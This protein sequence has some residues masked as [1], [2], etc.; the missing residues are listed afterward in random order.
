MA[1]WKSDSGRIAIIWLATAYVVVI[2]AA[3]AAFVIIVGAEHFEWPMVI[4]G[5]AISGL[6]IALISLSL[7]WSQ[8]MGQLQTWL[9]AQN[10]SNPTDEYRAAR[11]SIRIREGLGTNEPP[12]LES[13]R[14]A[15][16]HG[17]AW[18]PR[19]NKPVPHRED[20]KRS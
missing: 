1:N 15:A 20:R 10:R 4:W 5:L 11:R 3:A 17:G 13:V 8:P 6:V 19:T 16:N 2:G 7:R 9:M 14:D 18:V 12:T